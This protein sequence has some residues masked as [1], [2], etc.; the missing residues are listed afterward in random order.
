MAG[1]NEFA[2]TVPNKLITGKAYNIRIPQGWAQTSDL[3]YGIDVGFSKTLKNGEKATFFFHHETMPPEAVNPPSD[4]SAMQNQWDVML[5]N[6]YHDIKKINDNIP[7]VNGKVLINATYELVDDG[8]KL[9]RRYTYFMNTQTAFVVQCSASPTEWKNIMPEFDEIILTLLPSDTASVI[10]A[11]SDVSVI[12][13]LKNDLPTLLAT[14]PTNWTCSLCDVSVS[15]S[16]ADANRTLE[17][18]IAFTRKDVQ[19]IYKAA[20]LTFIAMAEGKAD[21]DLNFIPVEL[22]KTAPYSIDFI[23]YLG[24]MWGCAYGFTTN[25][26]PPIEQYKMTIYDYN[27]EKIGS[28]SISREDGSILLSDKVNSIETEKIAKMYKFD[29]QDNVKV[30]VKDESQQEYGAK[31]DHVKTNIS[32]LPDFESTHKE[33]VQGD[34]EAQNNLGV[35]YDNGIGVV[36]DDKEAVKWYLKAAEQG[37]ADAQNNLGVM[38]NNGKG[39]IEDDEEAVKWYRKAAE[40]GFA[41]AQCNLG[42]MYANGNGVIRDGKEAVKWYRKAIDQGLARAQFNLGTLY[43]YGNGVVK[44]DKEAVKWFLKAAEQ[45][46]AQAQYNLGV[47]YS[48]GYGVIEDDK[49]AIKWYLKAAE[50]GYAQ[51]QWAVGGMY[52]FGLAVDQNNK[53]AVKWWTKAADQGHVESQYNLGVMY[54]KGEGVVKDDNKAVKWHRKAAEQGHAKAQCYLGVMYANGEGVIKDYIEAY[55]WALLAEMNGYDVTE[56]K[57]SLRKKM[58]PK[59]IAEAQILAEA[60]TEKTE[61]GE[62]DTSREITSVQSISNETS[63]M[64]TKELYDTGVRSAIH[65]D[66]TIAKECLSKGKEKDSSN[67]PIAI[68]LVLAEQAVD[69][70]ITTETG[71]C[72]FKSIQEG[73]NKNWDESL[74]QAKKASKLAPNSSQVFLHLGTVY[75]GLVKANKGDSYAHDAINAYNRAIEID[76]K[77]GLAYYNLGVAQAAFRKWDSARQNLLKAKSLGVPVPSGLIKQIESRM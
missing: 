64:T 20:K 13:R 10:E 67:M 7:K 33:A 8:T 25:C 29:I 39:V 21:D 59:E 32:A 69:K 42:L 37:Y 51:A 45:G 11:V 53:E 49:E 12:A 16:S 65:G 56:F 44:D 22:R 6:K 1:Q 35:M 58:T 75:V 77:N 68:A 55:K 18:K 17:V 3:P 50:Q 34:V 72:V 38:Y 61:K 70:K 31:A 14:F 66:F 28:V 26:Q 9:W 41:E 27:E 30:E 2:K 43:A 62:Q 15:Q 19:D 74:N 4:T 5:K 73:N 48:K 46:Y 57:I 76:E 36:E 47:M 52:R 60:Y 54:D 71:I 40:Q 24:Q 63:R 23:K